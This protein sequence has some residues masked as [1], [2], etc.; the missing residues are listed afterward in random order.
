[1]TIQ[2]IPDFGL[3]INHLATLV[4]TRS[5]FYALSYSARVEKIT[6]PRVAQCVLKFKKI[7]F[8]IF[9]KTF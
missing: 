2:K 1:M 4:Q 8:L 5:P 6:T 7:D 9:R 3:K